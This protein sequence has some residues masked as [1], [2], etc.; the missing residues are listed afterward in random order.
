[1]QK[2]D[3]Q[4]LWVIAVV[5][6]LVGGLP[7]LTSAQELA[8]PT[9]S[10]DVAPILY[11]RCVA[12]HRAGEVAPM[13]LMTYAQTRPWARSIKAKVESREMPPWHADPLDGVA[14]RNDRSLSQDEI[15]TVVAWVDAGALEGNAADLPPSPTFREGWQ[16]PSGRPPDV[17]VPM[18]V[19]YEIPAEGMLEYIN[20]SAKMPLETDVFIEAVEARPD[21]RAAVHHFAAGARKFSEAPPPGPLMLGI[22]AL[23]FPQPSP[24]ADRPERRRSEGGGG[25]LVV[26]IPGAGF[27]R[28]PEGFGRRVVGGPDAYATF[29]MH[30]AVTGKPE[31]DRSSVG[32]WLRREPVQT[33]LVDSAGAMGTI[34]AQG[35]EVLWKPGR[36]AP[37]T[38]ANI[39]NIP[40]FVE[41]FETVM[42]VPFTDAATLYSLNPHAHVRGSAFNYRVVY[43]DG[44]E[45]VLLHVPKYDFNWQLLYELEEPLLV[46]AGSTIVVTAH[47]DNSVK[48]KYNP[49][50]HKEVVWADQSWE[51]MFVP[52]IEYAVG[53]DD[54]RGATQE[55]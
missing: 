5:A 53:V 35:R 18:P 20:F 28:Y 15:D 14:M 52:F 46:P 26:Y 2:A 19:E 6:L 1:M 12:C 10:K 37:L 30:Y 39:P 29:Q 45:Q 13:S 34:V 41:D 49:A 54:A 8:R 16:H 11:E 50:P 36:P 3:H 24:T 9:F 40:P 48:N 31:T 27:E 7:V 51:E 33:Q 38:Y 25:S 43:P 55:Q 32:L 4:R 44:R 23:N 42:V 22:D 21:N 17:I 47:Y